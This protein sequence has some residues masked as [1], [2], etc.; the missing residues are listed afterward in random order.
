MRRRAVALAP[1][2]LAGLRLEADGAR[3]HPKVTEAKARA[4]PDGSLEA[5]LLLDAGPALRTPHRCR[6]ISAPAGRADRGR[7]HKTLAAG[8]T[9]SA[10]SG[11][12]RAPAAPRSSLHSSDLAPSP[13]VLPVHRRQ[14]QAQRILDQPRHVVDAELFHD[15][16]A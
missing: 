6:A 16:R 10:H 1:K 3:L 12:A 2:A 5:V 11:R 4:L 13:V 14:V 8:G 7:R 15:G 9:G